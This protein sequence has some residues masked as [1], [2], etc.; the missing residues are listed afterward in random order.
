MSSDCAFCG[1]TIVIGLSSISFFGCEMA[2]GIAQQVRAD[3]ADLP[4][5]AISVA[6]YRLPAAKVTSASATP[7]P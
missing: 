6:R 2:P 5:E 3:C 4:C 7:L 1:I